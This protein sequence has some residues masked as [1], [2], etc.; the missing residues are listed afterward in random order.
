MNYNRTEIRWR[1][2]ELTLKK[3]GGKPTK[4]KNKIILSIIR[5]FL[6]ITV[7]TAILLTILTK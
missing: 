6:V 3:M 4:P 7:L 2:D 5:L 1:V